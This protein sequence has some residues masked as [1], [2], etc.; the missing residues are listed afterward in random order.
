MCLCTLI[1]ALRE[2]NLKR[3]EENGIYMFVTR[4]GLW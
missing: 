4:E 3:Y 1:E 2:V